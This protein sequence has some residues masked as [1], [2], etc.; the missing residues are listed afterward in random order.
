[1]Y[2]IYFYSYISDEIIPK[3]VVTSNHEI[4]KTINSVIYDIIV[5][6]EGKKKA[7]MLYIFKDD[8]KVLFDGLDDG[9]YIQQ[10]GNKYM[11]NKKII[12]RTFYNGWFSK[13]NQ[14]EYDYIKIGYIS[15]LKMPTIITQY[16]S[17][18]IDKKDN[19]NEYGTENMS[20]LK[21]PS[22]KIDSDN[23]EYGNG[24]NGVISELKS[25]FKLK[26]A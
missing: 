2:L 16:D 23:N 22:K 5:F 13:I 17:T 14:I 15:F 19:I 9:I 4:T 11:L 20:F 25:K 1:M 3:I 6:E 12:K 21:M 24:Y 10:M 26:N 8:E 18:K 7:D